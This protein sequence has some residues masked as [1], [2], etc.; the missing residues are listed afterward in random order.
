MPSATPGW[1]NIFVISGKIFIEYET[2]YHQCLYNPVAKFN[3]HSPYYSNLHIWSV[4]EP[5]SWL[6]PESSQSHN[7]S[8][9]L[10]S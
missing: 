3:N 8:A 4:D 5:L 6:R 1:R 10:F 9:E 2:F 7:R